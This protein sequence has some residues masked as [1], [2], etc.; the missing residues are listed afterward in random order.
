MLINT[1][2]KALMLQL[3]LKIVLLYLIVL[4]FIYHGRK[5]APVLY[6]CPSRAGQIVRNDRAAS[7]FFRRKNSQSAI[8]TARRKNSH[9]VLLT[10]QG[11]DQIITEMR[12]TYPISA[13]VLLFSPLTEVW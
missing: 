9:C 5:I 6:I 13:E 10:V 4:F 12:C 3:G 8:F 1:V 7:L 11:Y 2:K